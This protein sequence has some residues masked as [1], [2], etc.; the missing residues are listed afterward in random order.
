VTLIGISYLLAL[1]NIPSPH[2]K[3]KDNPFLSNMSPVLLP[4]LASPRNSY[5][6]AATLS[7]LFPLLAQ[8]A[9]FPLHRL[10]QKGVPCRPLQGRKEGD[11]RDMCVGGKARY[12]FQSGFPECAK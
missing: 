12:E 10:P 1:T 4:D 11:G 8:L 3:I 9:L 6:A 2:E 5:P 7:Q